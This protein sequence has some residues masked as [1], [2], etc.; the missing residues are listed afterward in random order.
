MTAW[1]VD[2]KDWMKMRKEAWKSIKPKIDSLIFL[3]KDQK[4]ALKSYFLKGEEDVAFPLNKMH[5]APLLEMWLHP[6]QSEQHWEIIKNKYDSTEW[7]NA[8]GRFV[9]MNNSLHVTCPNGESFFDGLEEHF[10]R[11]FHLDRF[12][13][14]DFSEYSEE[15]FIKEAKENLLLANNFAAYLISDNP[16]PYRITQYQIQRWIDAMSIGYE[17]DLI[18]LKWIIEKSSEVLNKSENYSELVVKFA[19]ELKMAL[20]DPRLPE[21]AKKDIA[22]LEAEMN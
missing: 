15:G 14:E 17:G 12:K 20:K 5:A 18:A 1:K 9:E 3:E 19:K 22:K 21:S 4:K 16:H 11:L 10:C 6:D 2:D 13:R 8:K 7:G